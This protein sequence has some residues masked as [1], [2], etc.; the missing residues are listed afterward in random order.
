[1][2]LSG[3]EEVVGSTHKTRPYPMILSPKENGYPH[4]YLF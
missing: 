1:V 4:C 2:Q 3:E